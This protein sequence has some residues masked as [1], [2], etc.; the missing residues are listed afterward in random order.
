MLIAKIHWECARPE[1]PSPIQS[2]R[3]VESERVISVTSVAFKVKVKRASIF[4]F[5]L[6]GF[7]INRAG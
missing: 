1:H 2:Y 3:V 4:A 6:D 5:E 7:T